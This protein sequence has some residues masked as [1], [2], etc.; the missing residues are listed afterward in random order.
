LI[1]RIFCLSLA[2]VFSLGFGPF[3]LIWASPPVEGKPIVVLTVPWGPPASDV[4]L[5]AQGQFLSPEATVL[6]AWSV[7]HKQ[8]YADE[9]KKNGA[10]LVLDATRLA[11]I[12][13][14]T[15]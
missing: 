13:G 5:R 12:C 7:L 11:K 10:W 1:L 4:I 3:A 8:T 6:A 9:L 14:V 15:L 2:V